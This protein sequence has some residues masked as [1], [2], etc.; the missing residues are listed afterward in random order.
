MPV[1]KKTGYTGTITWLGRVVDQPPALISHPETALYASLAGVE[2]EI[3]AGLTRPSC[4]RVS[5]QYPRGTEIANTRQFSVLSA[6]DL[7]LIAEKMGLATLDP[8]LIGASMVLSG[9]P[10]FSHIPPGSR[11]QAE[12]GA[13][14]VVDLEN[15]PCV[16]PGKPINAAHEGFGKRFKPA[17]EGRRGIVAWVERAGWFRL[18]DMVTLHIPDQPVWAL[19]AE[20]RARSDVPSA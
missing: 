17:A 15:R 4:S 18:G 20:A 11:L 3:H 13:T 12:G 1:L 19:L 14:L 16:F 6:E 7:T 9:I 5:D 8:G 2:G 10:D